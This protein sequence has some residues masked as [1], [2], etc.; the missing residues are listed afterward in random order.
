MK[1]L[2][3][4]L[5][6]TLLISCE[7]DNVELELPLLKQALT[8]SRQWDSVEYDWYTTLYDNGPLLFKWDMLVTSNG[9][10]CWDNYTYNVDVYTV[11]ESHTTEELIIR[12]NQINADAYI[13]YT[14]QLS[15]EMLILTS[16]SYNGDGSQ[17]D[18][19]EYNIPFTPSNDDLEGLTPKCQ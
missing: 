16:S 11:I 13:L 8:I 12:V 3:A 1:K 6:L 18:G 4:I 9:F 14:Y 2:L 15:D 19:T 17:I 5:L 7:H 10:K